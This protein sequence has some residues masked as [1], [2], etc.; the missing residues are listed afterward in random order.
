MPRGVKGTLE[1]PEIRRAKRA[2]RH[3]ANRDAELARM[4]KWHEDHPAER[5]AYRNA[6]YLANIEREREKARRNWPRRRL[7][8][9]GL[10]EEMFVEYLDAQ[11]ECCAFCSQPLPKSRSLIA[12]DHDH[13]TGLFRGL[14]HKLCNAVIGHADRDD[15]FVGYMAGAA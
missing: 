3:L 8:M 1:S 5:R 6:Y 11:E 12:I 9:Y 13:A 14:V 10:T 2:A 15:N 4:K 7:R